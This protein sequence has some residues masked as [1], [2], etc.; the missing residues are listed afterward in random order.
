MPAMKNI[1]RG[2]VSLKKLSI[3][4]PFYLMFL[5]QNL[6]ISAAY[7]PPDNIALDC[8]SVANNNDSTPRLWLADAKYL[9]QP[10]NIETV[11]SNVLGTYIDPIPYKTARLSHSHFSYTFNVTPGQKFV[12]LHFYP[13]SYQEF[14]R[15]TA[16][17]DVHIGRY[18]LLSNFSAA[19][20]ADNLKLKAFSKEFCIN[21]ED[22]QKLKISFT[23]NRSMPDLYAFIN[24]IEIVSMPDNLYYSADNDTGF[25]FV[26]E[27]TFTRIEK[28]MALEMVYRTNVGGKFL[29]SPED[30]GMHRSWSTDV[31][32]L[33]DDGPSAVPI[34]TSI[35]LNFSK[36]RNYT[37][38][39][40]IY[41]TGRLM[42][43]DK[44]MN[45]NYRLT[46]QFQVDGF[47]YLVRLHFCE[48]QTEITAAGDRIFQIYIHDLVAENEA[49]VVSWAGGSRIPVYRD[50]AV[51]IASGGK[52]GNQ[53]KTNLSIA[54]HPGPVLETLYSDAILNGLEIFKLSNDGN[55]A[56]PN[57]DPDLN[58]QMSPPSG[59]SPS[60]LVK[61]KNDKA[62]KITAVGGVAGLF[63]ISLLCFMI[64]QF[65]SVHC[66]SW[67]ALSFCS[68]T[69]PNSS[70]GPVLPSNICRHFSLGE[71]KT[72][73][74]NF[75]NTSVI[76]AGG[77]GNVYKAFIDGGSKAVAIK[78]QNPGSQQGAH[79]FRTEIE[80]LS[81]LRHH[82]LVS[83]IGYCDDNNE[84]ILVYDYMVHGALR[85]HLYKTS[86][87]QLDWKQRL[88]ICIGAAHGLH[89][90]HRGPNHTIIHR[91]VKTTNILLGEKWVAKVSDFGLSKM[92]N[93]SK[94][95]ISTVVK[96]SFGYLDPEYY[97]LLRLT[98]KSDVYSFGVVLCEV[99]CARA[100]INPTL[101]RMQI[102]LV[103]W[104]QHCYNNG[105][106]DQIIDPHL[107]GKINPAS[108]EKFAEVAINCLASEGI[109][110]PAMS[111]VVC[112]LE[113]AL[114]LQERE[115]NANA[116]NH[117]NDST[118]IDY[119]VLFTSGSGSMNTGR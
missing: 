60:R 82:N 93:L 118:V 94:T 57:P 72:A 88:R 110:R 19:L 78:R 15:S 68:K 33:T 53:K 36:I 21:V 81:Q 49:D 40:P 107:Q 51:M 119:H 97:R 31:D 101:D 111:E 113:L 84:M 27:L 67:C 46:W 6:N 87:L 30:T 63:T 76:G 54:L 108:L 85:D 44:T 28:N 43:T 47:I 34:N 61:P 83:L 39:V 48:F 56:G 109:K 42:G 32:Y 4:A 12:R 102:S 13:T 80:M 16:L 17:F 41:V 96:G 1:K 71:I 7:T 59:A 29:P 55:L 45:G 116:E 89:Y 35:K 117:L 3:P 105:T 73:T 64:S 26:N 52:A 11:V 75:E 25:L 18:T 98:E 92:N 2:C 23:S 100:P 86:N 112:G 20:T 69:E 103:E 8:G 104:A 9:D 22:N 14:N 115:M 66:N 37:A 106:L 5:L 99:L 79:E 90:L 58:L 65:G 50:Y 95:H 114:E 91:D 24:G 62:A 10:K 77:F 70:Y 38:P 74:N